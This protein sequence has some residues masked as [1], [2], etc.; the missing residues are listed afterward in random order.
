[1]TR[2]GWVRLVVAMLCATATVAGGTALTAT[3]AVAVVDDFTVV[4]T[5]YSAPSVSVSGVATVPLTV[6]AHITR[7][8]PLPLDDSYLW[9]QVDRSGGTGPLTSMFAGAKFISGTGSDGVW[10]A[11]LS[12]PST[13]A[14][15]WAL[16]TIGEAGIP[17]PIHPVTGAPTFIVIGTHQP[18][19]SAGTSPAVVPV[20]ASPFTVKGRVT[21]STTGLGM[22]GVTV[23]YGIDNTCAESPLGG[24]GATVTSSAGYYGFPPQT[25]RSA[26]INVNCVIVVGPASAGA[27]VITSRS[28]FVTLSTW[29]SAAPALTR[30][31]IGRIVPVTGSVGGPASF[32][33]I[34]L[35]RLRGSTVW[36]AV[37]NAKVRESGRFTLTAQ[38]S[39]RGPNIYRVLMPLCG[40][41]LAARTGPWIISGT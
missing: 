25:S 30:A 20:G 32:C 6:T 27:P 2:I 39:V 31:P 22:A 37:S 19:V 24:Y 1:M 29:V 8:T 9:F 11:T 17:G 7:T 13:A 35:Q 41:F 33:P 15:T 5:T 4:S 21:D 3:A 34:Q 36:R 12:V 23:R 14:G 38:P 26:K 40:S 10:A 16:T 18:R 28:F